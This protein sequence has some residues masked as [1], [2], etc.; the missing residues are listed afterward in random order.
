MNH[1]WYIPTW[2]S[3]FFFYRSCFRPVNVLKINQIIQGFT[4]MNTCITTWRLTF[5]NYTK[6]HFTCKA[7]IWLCGTGFSSFYHVEALEIHESNT[8]QNPEKGYRS[9]FKTFSTSPIPRNFQP[10]WISNTLT[11]LMH[12]NKSRPFVFFL[13]YISFHWHQTNT[14]DSG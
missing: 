12:K 6:R 14:S 10:P 2:Y 5:H 1:I 7:C 13:L 4:A 9:S 3:F 11:Y 8:S